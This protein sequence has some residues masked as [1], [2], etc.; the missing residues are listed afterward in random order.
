MLHL[1]SMMIPSISRR[2]RALT[3]LQ[4]T[5]REHSNAII[6][7]NYIVRSPHA[8]MPIPET[9][10]F[11]HVFQHFPKYGKKTTLIDGVTG[12][13]YS[14]NEVQESVVNMA[15]GQVRSGM[16]KKDVL[17][18]V[19]PNSMEFCTTF[20]STLSMGGIVSTCNP[21]YTSEELAYQFKNS[22]SST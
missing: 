4:A 10:F 1:L 2:T 15:S 8:A 12:R 22:N 17:A 3:K 9:N 21:N 7:N 14:Y 11:S 13:E 20:F 5:A 16:Q 19:S 6:D 18:L